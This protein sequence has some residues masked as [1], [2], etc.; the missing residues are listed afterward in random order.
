MYT[1]LIVSVLV[2]FLIDLK[3]LSDL[4][5]LFQGETKL[6]SFPKAAFSI[7]LAYAYLTIDSISSILTCICLYLLTSSGLEDSFSPSAVFIRWGGIS[8]LIFF[9]SISFPI[10]L[11]I[12]LLWDPFLEKN[13]NRLP[14][15]LAD[16]VARYK[17][18]K[19]Q[20][21][22]KELLL[23]WAE[24]MDDTFKW[25]ALC[26][27]AGAILPYLGVLAVTN[28]IGSI[29]IQLQLSNV[30]IQIFYLLQLLSDWSGAIIIALLMLNLVY[31][32]LPEGTD[33]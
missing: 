18:E 17:P 2:I 30:A 8:L 16:W 9:Y 28:V 22:V 13:N 11:A 6:E 19:L 12:K 33:K 21:T 5:N 15:R 1:A 3:L 26:I 32:S 31:L 27:V 20:K 29:S 25:I 23:P 14:N 7:N 4:L 10:R 24:G